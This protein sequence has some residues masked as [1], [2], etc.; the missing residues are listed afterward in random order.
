MDVAGMNLDWVASQQ[1]LAEKIRVSRRLLEVF[2]LLLLVYSKT[3]VESGSN[4]VL[5]Q[6]QVSGCL[7]QDDLCCTAGSVSFQSGKFTP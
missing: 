5:A 2:S 3:T 6:Q 1:T 4:M 7:S